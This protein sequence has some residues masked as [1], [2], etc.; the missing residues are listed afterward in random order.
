MEH[1]DVRAL[2]D[3]A[4]VEPGGLDRLAAGDTPE[5]AAVA[6]HLAGCD[7]C[8]VELVRLARASSV[9]REAIA[10]VPPDGLRERT[11]AFVESLG[12]DRSTPPFAPSGAPAEAAAVHVPRSIPG[13]PPAAWLM[14][15]A[16]VVVL[17]VAATGFLVSAVNQ[18]AL[19]DRD[20]ALARHEQ[21]VSALAS[22]TTWS[23]R[24]DGEPDAARV[25][26]DSTSG[27]ASTATVLFS[28]T[29]R[30]L[31]VVAD[32]LPHPGEGREVRCWVETDGKRERIGRMYFGGGLAYWVGA[33]D[34][35]AAV[36]RGT[37]FGM[38]VVDEDG[39]PLGEPVLLGTLEVPR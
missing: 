19:D 24:V 34:A 21:V 37:V 18:G 2:I 35:L 27:D 23:L 5:A 3:L 36:K 12:R 25:V 26:L 16:A 20:R 33:V 8:A 11:L 39:D 7:L 15:M 6:G 22:V 17:S 14:A 1:A 9:L 13:R 10:T 38:T 29:S 32:A 30:E 31:V 4:A 28:R